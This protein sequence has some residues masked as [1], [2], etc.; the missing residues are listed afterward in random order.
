V[1]IENFEKK[2]HGRVKILGCS[3]RQH[4]TFSGRKLLA[5][6]KNVHVLYVWMSNLTV[7]LEK[8]KNLCI[9]LP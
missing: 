7:K 9:F 3:K 8:G 1:K 6:S 5:D 2:I 4:G